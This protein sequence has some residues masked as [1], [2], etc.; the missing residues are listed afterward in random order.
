M[1]PPCML[2]AVCCNACNTFTLRTTYSHALRLPSPSNMFSAGDR[3]KKLIANSYDRICEDIGGQITDIGGQI[4]ELDS[5][6]DDSG[7]ELDA[8]LGMAVGK[9][10][11]ERSKLRGELLEHDSEMER[12]LQEKIESAVGAV[13]AEDKNL[14]VQAEARLGRVLETKADSETVGKNMEAMEKAEVR[15][16]GT[17]ADQDFVV[18]QIQSLDSRVVDVEASMVPGGESPMEALE[19]SRELKLK[20]QLAEEMER[21]AEEIK[22]E[23]VT[24]LEESGEKER[25][26]L[27]KHLNVLDKALKSA[28]EGSLNG[29]ETLATRID[30]I[31]DALGRKCTRH[32]VR[33]IRL[34]QFTQWLHVH[35]HD[36]YIHTTW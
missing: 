11:E 14:L 22:G 26:S 9:E 31:Q 33:L 27:K 34:G 12:D 5:K 15:A 30:A 18:N 3:V 24:A 19:A 10:G 25:L 35:S 28:R 17:K 29:A 2:S 36:T 21:R 23:L 7:R 13:A 8:K 20:Q 1:R 32:E 6:V 4:T 16:L